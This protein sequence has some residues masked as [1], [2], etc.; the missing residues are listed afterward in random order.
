MELNDIENI[1]FKEF[2]KYRGSMLEFQEQH[3]LIFGTSSKSCQTIMSNVKYFF[4]SVMKK[5]NEEYGEE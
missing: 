2:A 1:I 3:R 5:I 4:E